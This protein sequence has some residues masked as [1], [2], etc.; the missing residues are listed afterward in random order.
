MTATVSRWARRYVGVA[1][2]AL[3]AWQVGLLVGVPRGTEV[4]LGLYGFVLHVVFGKAYSLV[5]SYFDRELAE[6]RAAIAQL[7]LTAVGTACLA[8]APLRSTPDTLEAAGAVLWAAGVVVFVGTLAWTVRDNLTGAETGTG[9]PNAHRA[10]VDRAA[11]AVVP[12]ALAYLLV[13]SYATLGVAGVVPPVFDGY[14]P[15]TTHLLGTGTATLLVFG[16]GARLLPRFL[17][18][19]PPKSLVWVVLPAG[20]VGPVLLAATLPAGPGFHLA[21]AVETV[22]VVGYAAIVGTLFV[23]SDNRRTALYGVLLGAGG[24]VAAVALGAWF[25]FAGLDGALVPAHRRLTLLGFLG[26]T[27]VGV[28]LQFYPPN[29]GRWPGC[30]DRTALASMA[31]LAVGVAV[32]AVGAAVLT[33]WIE[34]VGVGLALVGTLGYAYLLAGA[35]AT[36]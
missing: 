13:G 12:V 36:R 33:T 27:V 32:Q 1:V 7:P 9:G 19:E 22:A 20:A 21:A 24:G 31:L 35:F 29:V 18:A 3:F 10:G 4:A 15:R 5:P 17:V 14:P 2:A 28:S 26:L 34:S 30:D 8:L 11:N 6:P 23:R 25:A 16:I